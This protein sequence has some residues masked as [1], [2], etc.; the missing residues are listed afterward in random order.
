MEAHI[1]LTYCW[2]QEYPTSFF[3]TLDNG[4]LFEA[5]MGGKPKF[6]LQQWLSHCEWLWTMWDIPSNRNAHSSI[7]ITAGQK[8]SIST[9]NC[10]DS[11]LGKYQTG[12]E[13]GIAEDWL[14][15]RPLFLLRKSASVLCFLL[16][17]LK[18]DWKRGI[19]FM[20]ILF[21]ATAALK[22]LDAPQWITFV[23]IHSRKYF[24]NADLPDECHVC[25]DWAFRGKNASVF[26]TEV[27]A[28]FVRAAVF[29]KD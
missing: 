16:L 22:M 12:T 15:Y 6:I 4:W 21:P 9:L 28:G 1:P 3:L 18:V 2:Q 8:W 19:P 7:L 24:S 27:L 26:W 23:G 13:M 14:K 20:S 10:L 11:F 29:S 5:I 25:L 17:H